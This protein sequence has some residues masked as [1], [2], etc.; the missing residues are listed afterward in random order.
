MGFWQGK[1]VLVTGGAG[2]LGS[3]LC[4]QLKKNEARVFITKSSDCDLTKLEPLLKVYEK[5]KPDIVFHAAADV[6]GIGYN[7]ISPADIFRNNMLMSVNILEASRLHPV[8]K[9]IMIGSAC[10]YP[11]K[12]DGLMAEESFLSGPMHESVEVYG[13]S[14]RALYLGGKAYQKQYG[15]NSIFLLL[16]NLYGPRDKFDPK[17]SHVVAALVKKFADAKSN[18]E[19][20]VSCWGTGTPIR[21]FMYAE[22]C[23][24][25]I[26]KTAEVY[27]G[28][29]PVNIGTGGGISIKEL[30]E[31]VKEV[32][33][34]TGD[35]V[36]DT[37]MPDGAMY[38]ALNID[39]LKNTVGYSDFTSLKEGLKKTVAWY[40]ENI[41]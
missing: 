9:L 33:G 30:S 40:L 32:T 5:Y 20:T 25:A 29:E 24:R 16:T 36:W 12:A 38:K 23:A 1:N 11:G 8:Q 15:L 3:H 18:N 21:E 37:S 39:K 28:Q 35:I 34:Y 7:R 4:D 10:A 2:F 17:E 31:T 41:C 19:P 14:K 6:G 27:D 26:L 22:D 13:L